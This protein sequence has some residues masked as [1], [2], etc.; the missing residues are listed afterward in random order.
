MA[1]LLAF[2]LF[3]YYTAFGV[4]CQGG[5]DAGGTFL[6]KS[7]PRTPFKKLCISLWANALAVPFYRS[8]AEIHV[9]PPPHKKAKNDLSFLKIHKKLFFKKVSYA[10]FGAG[11]QFLL[12]LLVWGRAP[13]S[14]RL[15]QSIT[16]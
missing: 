5:S 15:S 2:F 14:R 13:T 7:S 6:K 16:A 11:P 3:L 1:I 12:S 8:Q 9:G 4:G 10:G